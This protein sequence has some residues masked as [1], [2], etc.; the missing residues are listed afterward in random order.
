[1]CVE[2]KNVRL[3]SDGAQVKEQVCVERLQQRLEEE[4]EGDDALVV[5]RERVQVEEVSHVDLAEHEEEDDRVVVDVTQRC[6]YSKKKKL[7]NIL[8]V[9]WEALN[10]YCLQSKFLTVH[11]EAMERNDPVGRIRH[12]A[13]VDAELASKIR[14]GR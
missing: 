7:A 10:E 6:H 5:R 3:H 2:L 8:W 12:H 4:A 11:R 1:M 14:L 9:F 13:A